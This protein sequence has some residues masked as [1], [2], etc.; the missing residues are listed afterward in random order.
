[1]IKNDPNG[2]YIVNVHMPLNESPTP[3]KNMSGP[4]EDEILH[5]DYPPITF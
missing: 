1:V 3:L 5:V 4:G 2:F